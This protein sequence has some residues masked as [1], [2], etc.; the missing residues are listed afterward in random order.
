[1]SWTSLLLAFCG[2][3]LLALSMEKHREQVFGDRPTMAPPLALTCAGWL[4]LGLAAMP[5]ISHH[6]AS[7]GLAVWTGELSIAAITVVLLHTYA[8]RWIPIV[9][10]TAAAAVA[11]LALMPF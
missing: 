9:L 7:I 11:A 1:M 4:L 3:A 8:P 10:A 2:L 6:G 5:P